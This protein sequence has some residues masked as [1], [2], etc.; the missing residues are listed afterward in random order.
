VLLL[1]PALAAGRLEAAAF[2]Y[3][4]PAR[5]FNDFGVRG[6]L[7]VV[8]GLLAFSLGLA[9]GVVFGRTLP[10]VLVAGGLFLVAIMLAGVVRP[11][12]L[13]REEL[14]GFDANTS[15]EAPLYF[16]E[17]FRLPDGRLLTFAESTDLRPP[18]ARQIDTGPYLRWLRTSGWHRVDIGIP[19]A[20]LPD[21][22]WREGLGTL[23]AAAGAF[24]AA[25]I[26][27]RRRRP[28][29]GLALEVD[30]R[31]SVVPPTTTTPRVRPR[32]RRNGAWLSVLMQTKVGRPETLG[33]IVAT[34][35][36]VGASLVVLQLLQGARVAQGCVDTQCIGEG[37]YARIN[38]PLEEWL[39]P[40]LATL[41]F[42][43]GG[44]LGA[45]ILAREFESGTGRLTWSLT[46]G[47]LR[48]LLWRIVPS[49]LLVVILLTPAAIVGSW[50]IRDRMMLD[51]TYLFG[52]DQLRGAPLVARGVALFGAGLLAGLVFRR[53][54]PALV[55]TAIVGV[56]LY[57]AVEWIESN[58]HL[59]PYD[60][61]PVGHEWTPG[62]WEYSLGLEAPDGSFRIASELA[63]DNGFPRDNAAGDLIEMDPTFIAWYTAR[64]Y[65]A[66]DAGW[67]AARHPEWV[68][69]ES[70]L[71]VGVGLLS[72]VIAGG[73]LRRTR[74]D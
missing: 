3:L 40:L 67:E 37:P 30:A 38:N 2:P 62:S 12:L 4:D 61:Y 46:G 23:L 60:Y 70:V 28:V 74:P 48:W 7:V 51:P 34:L 45:P 41:P 9:A 49:V 68:V 65:R 25:A 55:V 54:L 24:L 35:L 59:M 47:R 66:V 36:V 26:A 11:S 8:R 69:R 58:G 27:V 29:P 50:L 17:G 42:V 6:L 5:S 39:Y 64:G 14:P 72:T 71:F 43:V 18:E 56:L 1:G 73:L 53:M 22:E 13:P 33:A 19:G 32:W 52:F 63:L 57:N 21:I 15:A 44:L 10:A 31:R 16:G 20:R